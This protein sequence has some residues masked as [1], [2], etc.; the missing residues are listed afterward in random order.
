M[1]L[2][3]Q[4]QGFDVDV[5]SEPGALIE[6]L[7][8]SVYDLLILDAPY[9]ES[10]VICRSLRT[11]ELMVPI[12]MLSSRARVADR[13]DALDAGADDYLTKPVA[14]RELNAHVRAL[15]RRNRGP[16]IHPIVVADLR[17]DP[18]TRQVSRRRRRIELTSREFALLEYLMRHADQPVS[19]STI[20][21][22]VWGVNWDR[23][24]NV[25]DVFISHL[26]KKV[27]LPAERPLLHAVRGVGYVIGY[28][29]ETP[30]AG[31]AGTPAQPV[32][33]VMVSSAGSGA[34]QPV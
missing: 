12:L 30:L 31:A 9:R 3:L 2:A 8:G 26:R 21:E 5:T 33:R 27:D 15:L 22:R 24:T 18:V 29:V 32:G 20:A 34:D 4:T 19:R 1:R 7:R 10:L 11:A 23:L 13:V 6:C 14:P 17:L 28:A 25:I 16:A